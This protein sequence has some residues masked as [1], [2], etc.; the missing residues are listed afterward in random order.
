[1]SIP[2]NEE[3]FFSATP[4]TRR[5]FPMDKHL[6]LLQRPLQPG[7]FHICPKCLGWFALRRVHDELDD[8]EGNLSRYR[9]V[10]CDTEFE[11]AWSHP[12]GVV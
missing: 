6:S 3:E 5:N 1:M 2:P 11:F 9:C 10:K 8:E 7:P 4:T 12:P